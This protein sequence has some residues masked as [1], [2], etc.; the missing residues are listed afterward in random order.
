MESALRLFMCL[1]IQEELNELK[2]CDKREIANINIGMS[3]LSGRELLW[4][5]F[6]FS[7]NSC[8]PLEIFLSMPRR[9]NLL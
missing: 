1:N 8:S 5:K 7:E 9:T 6:R 3:E 2:T 4:F